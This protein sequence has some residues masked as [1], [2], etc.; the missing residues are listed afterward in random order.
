MRVTFGFF[1][2]LGILVVLGI[3][4]CGGALQGGY[5]KGGTTITGRVLL[6]ENCVSCPLSVIL[7]DEEGPLSTALTDAEGRFSFS[8]VPGSVALLYVRCGSVTM[9]KGV[10]PLDEG[11]VNDV[12]F[13]DAF[14]T[15]QVVI[16]EVAWERYPGAVFIRDIPNFLVPQNFVHLVEETI[17][18]CEDPFSSPLVRSEAFR[19]IDVWFGTSS[20]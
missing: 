3:S 9:A 16:Y 5:P 1:M 14:S 17:S 10:Y 11:E 6:P 13:I 2:V 8:R 12:G 20:E 19:C 18:R 15:A 7:Y 4:G